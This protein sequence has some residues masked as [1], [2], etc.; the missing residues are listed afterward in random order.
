MK[1]LAKIN[2]QYFYTLSILLIL[3][4]SVGY[5]I[6]NAILKNE[7][8]EDILEKEYAIIQEIKTQNDLPNIYPI[9]ETKEVS[10]DKVMPKSYKKMYLSDEAEGEIEPYL[11]YT[12]TIKIN[13][14]YY[15]I[16]LRHSI[17]EN[18]DL[19]LAIALP[20]LMLLL[21]AFAVSYFTTGKLNKT[22]WTDFENNLR[23][24]E[25]YSFEENHKL[26]LQSSGIEEFD[27]LN[28]TIVDLT[29]KLEKDYHTLKEFTENASHELQT[30]LSIILLNLEEL[31]Q[32]DM[33]EPA[34][35]QVVSSIN[36]VKRLSVLNHS[37]ILLTKI[38]NNQFRAKKEININ[39]ILK[40]KMK[41]FSPLIEKQHLKIT[42]TSQDIFMVKLDKELAGILI[43]NL[44]SN[45]VKHNIPNG[46]IEIFTD[47][48][49]LKICN[50]GEDTTLNNETI[51]NRFT[52]ENSR[53]FGLGLAIVKQICE[54][55]RLE[56]NYSKKGRHCLTILKNE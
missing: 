29:A 47:K 42:F 20:L 24:I 7:I 32:Q 17:L 46:K 52:K 44:L 41:E 15:V 2:R 27:R 50:T 30:P 22:V 9:I 34:F 45:A 33:P 56:I 19:I 35:R 31:L 8:H 16:K 28:K 18:N 37:L 5:F 10:K 6:L 36:A 54:K 53:S 43:G 13:G 25:D 48:T 39:N 26:S 55:H 11:E 40:S 4:S 51:F 38:E 49:I 12:N 21:L 14:R 23:K 3:V 1:F